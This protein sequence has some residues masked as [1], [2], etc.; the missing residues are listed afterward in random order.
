LSPLIDHIIHHTL[1]AFGSS[2]NESQ[3]QLVRIPDRYLIYAR[4]HQMR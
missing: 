3:L 4:V 1:L 2:L